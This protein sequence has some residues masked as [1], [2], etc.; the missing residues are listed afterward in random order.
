MQW[1]APFDF[2]INGGLAVDERRG[3]FHF[4][5][6]LIGN[7]ALELDEY[8]LKTYFPGLEAPE[9]LKILAEY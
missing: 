8:V 9:Y 1:Y 6:I 3:E 4:P 7:D 5:Q 2:Y